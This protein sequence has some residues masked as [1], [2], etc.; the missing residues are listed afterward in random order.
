M[1]IKLRNY[2]LLTAFSVGQYIPFPVLN[3]VHEM[4]LFRTATVEI[5][6]TKDKSSKTEENTAN[7]KIQFLNRL[8][9]VNS[10][11][12]ITFV[13]CHFNN[14]HPVKL[15]YACIKRE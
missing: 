15:I 4:K 6:N 1:F 8:V 5:I 9:A 2:Q 10:I 11:I 14:S 12:T 13:N 3:V 7:F